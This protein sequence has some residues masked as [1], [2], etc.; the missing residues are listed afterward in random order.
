MAAPAPLLVVLLGLTLLPLLFFPGAEAGEVGVCWGTVADNLPSPAAVVQ[1]LKR[2]SIT[3][4]RIYD[5]DRGVIR[6]LANT[7]IKLMV[8]LPNEQLASAASSPPF[9]RQWVQ[10]N[11]AAFYPTTRIN[12]VAVGNEV[13]DMAKG[14]TQQLVP[15]MRNVQAALAGLGL[16]GA[17]KVSTPVA[18][19]ALKK[20]WPPSEGAFQDDIAQ[21]VMRPMVAF[22][23]QTGSPFMINVYPFRAYLDDPQH[24]SVAYW[25]FQPNDG[26][27]DPD[28]GRRYYN[29]Y[30]AQMDAV[31]YAIRSVSPGSVRASV[32]TQDAGGNDDDILL[33]SSEIGCSDWK[34]PKKH[35]KNF[36]N[37]LIAHTLGASS[38]RA[39]HTSGL[40][41]SVGA[42]AGATSAYIFALFNEDKKSDDSE[43]NFGLFY[44]DMQPVY[45]VDFVHGSGPVTPA[46]APA[47]SWCVANA[48]VGDA[49]LQAALDYACGHGA[50]CGAIQPGARC[51]SPDTKVAHATYAMNDYYQRH[52][53]ASQACDFNGAGSI[54]YQQP[55]ICD[56]SQAAS[57]CVARAEVG[58]ARLQA[59]LDWACGHG[60]DCSA[61]QRGGRCFDPDT[62]VSHASYAFNDYYQRN[63]RASQACNFNG[64]GSIVYQAPKIGNCQ[65]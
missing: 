10:D 42:G 56:P 22:L 17:I 48:G 23:R 52:G 3:M 13:F 7:G 25:T 63:G 47:S 59:A 9:A 30:D 53:R 31:R 27:V 32:T 36:A 20:S 58:D 21:S 35:C 54:V 11:V 34:I 62:K 49:R 15:A 8:S 19:T 1:L 55:S 5:T 4:V 29:L 24:I 40:L 43:R 26:V 41:D 37:G 44:P 64:A 28:T 50:D 45:D 60:A 65:L 2:Q 61:I 16:D 6:A 46:P 51:F 33:T 57:W 12:G 39:K 14:L 18:F 38:A